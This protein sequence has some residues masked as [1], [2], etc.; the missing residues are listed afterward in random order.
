MQ[1]NPTNMTPALLLVIYNIHWEDLTV[2]I[3]KRCKFISVTMQCILE[4][5]MRSVHTENI[6]HESRLYKCYGQPFPLDL[7]FE[8]EWESIALENWYSKL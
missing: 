5:N 3:L 8:I 6:Q 1:W 4:Y 2:Y 7:L